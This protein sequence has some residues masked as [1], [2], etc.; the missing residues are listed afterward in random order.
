MLKRIYLLSTLSA[1]LLSGC[2]V[3]NEVFNAERI[4]GS[5]RVIEEK[6]D[7][8]GFTEVRLSAVG[9]LSVQQGDGE[10]LTIEAEDNILPR[11][12]TDVEGG[13]LVIRVDRGFSISPTVTIR[14]NLTVKELAALEVSGSGEIRTG[15]I[16]S[17]DFR[18]RVSGSGDIRLGE[19][20]AD[21]LT[22]EI[23]GSGT[24]KAPG[25]VSSQRIR[26]SGSG[27]YDGTDLQSRSADIAISG[28]GDSKVWVQDD[29]SANIS[30]SGR[31]DYYGTPKVSQHTSGSGKIHN[32]GSRP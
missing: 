23:S 31:V 3:A 24:I 30:G 25:K 29:L 6:R 1:L 5:G 12:R 7:V 21:T 2:G 20:T 14:Y 19:L 18:M 26:I 9:E 15:T 22:M 27:D 28:S 17:R 32:L 10:S 13:A 16:R 11:I 4:R 8:R